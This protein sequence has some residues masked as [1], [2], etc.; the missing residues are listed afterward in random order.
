VVV[1][2]VIADQIWP[3]PAEAASGDGAGS[4]AQVDP[5]PPDR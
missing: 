3:P 2:V 1:A 5:A 4:A